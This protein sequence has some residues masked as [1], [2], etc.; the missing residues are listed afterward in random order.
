MLQVLSQRVREE[1]W[2][3]GAKK[4]PLE[5]SFVVVPQRSF[6]GATPDPDGVI[7]PAPLTALFEME[8][9]ID[10]GVVKYTFPR[11]GRMHG[12]EIGGSMGLT[13]WAAF[14]VTRHAF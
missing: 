7:D 2:R 8:P 10:D 6:G 9:T 12:I 13:T 1:L 3:F 11:S 5:C 4:C 14:S